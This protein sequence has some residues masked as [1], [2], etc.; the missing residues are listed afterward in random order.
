[1]ARLSSDARRTTAN[2]LTY[3]TLVFGIV[4]FFVWFMLWVDTLVMSEQLALDILKLVLPPICAL[5][6][7]YQKQVYD[8]RKY[9][10]KRLDKCLDD[11]NDSP[12]KQPWE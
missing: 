7:W 12:R 4:V 6:I 8:Q 1:M 5:L 9:L 11:K 10:E 2:A 3:A